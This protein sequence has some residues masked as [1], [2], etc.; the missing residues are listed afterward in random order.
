MEVL[1]G[2]AEADIMDHNRQATAFTLLKVL[3]PLPQSLPG[4]ILPQQV[5]LEYDKNTVSPSQGL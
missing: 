5:T 2:Y 4:I 1:L 3:M